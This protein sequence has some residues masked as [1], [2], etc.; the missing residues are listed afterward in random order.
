MA[1]YLSVLS[2][3]VT[4]MVIYNFPRA[5]KWLKNGALVFSCLLLVVISGLRY[6][7]GTDY[8]N[9]MWMYDG[10]SGEDPITIYEKPGL[11]LIGRIAAFI[12]NHH[13]TWFIMMALLTVSLFFFGIKKYSVNVTMSVFLFIFLGVWHGSFNTVKQH[14]AAAIFFASFPFL[15]KKDFL[16]WM[17][18]CVLATFFHEASLIMLPMYFIFTFEH[19]YMPYFIVALGLAAFVGKDIIIFAVDILKA[20]EKSMGDTEIINQGVGTIRTI[21]S[22]APV[23]FYCLFCQPNDFIAHE[24]IGENVKDFEHK[25]D[26]KFNCLLNIAIFSAVMSVALSSSV[27]FIRLLIFFDVFNVLFVPYLVKPFNKE[28]K[29]VFTV[30]ILALYCVFWWVDITKASTVNYQ[31]VFMIKE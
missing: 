9:Y 7:V 3:I 4:A 25:T 26:K 5:P 6:N 29:N 21:V 22:C 20:N 8:M 31:W 24:M 1:I 27:Y 15:Y 13:T 16:S 19:K 14:A 17:F 28:K 2:L 12:Y 23:F 30:L 11:H 10:Y 18:S